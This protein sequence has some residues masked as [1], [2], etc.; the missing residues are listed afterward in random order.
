MIT[1]VGTIE[2]AQEAEVGMGMRGLTVAIW[3][4]HQVIVKSALFLAACG[5]KLI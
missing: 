5:L 1:V 2:V 4:I 3:I